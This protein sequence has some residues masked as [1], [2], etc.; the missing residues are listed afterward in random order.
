MTE[1][2]QTTDK[3]EN[4]PT[5]KSCCTT[6][7]RLPL[8][9]SSVALLGVIILLIMNLSG[10][11]NHKNEAG[12]NKNGSISVAYVN[13]DTLMLHY[14]MV[15]DLRAS[16]EKDKNTL[17]A[18]ILNKQKV[19]QTK[20]DNYKSNLQ[21]NRINMQQAQAAEQQLGAEQQNLLAQRESY[22]NQLSQKQ[23]EM[24]QQIQDSVYNYVHRINKD[25]NYDYVLG[26][27]K[28]GGIILANKTY[29]I[30]Q[31]I[32]DGLNKEYKK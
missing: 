25:Y 29:D 7:S 6:C 17:E 15:K 9:M 19:L 27:A 20:I 30:T 8:I 1:E 5:E 3:P 18:E 31:I 11:K 26:F 32:I 16:L 21:A 28:G 4:T 22:L 10:H 24:D 2:I 14:N 12:N 13:Y 23:M